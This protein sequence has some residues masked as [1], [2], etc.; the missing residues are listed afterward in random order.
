MWGELTNLKRIKDCWRYQV[1]RKYNW[2]LQAKKPPTNTRKL[3]LQN[4]SPGLTW[5]PITGSWHLKDCLEK[6]GG[7]L[8]HTMSLKPQSFILPRAV[9]SL[10]DTM[11]NKETISSAWD[12]LFP[13]FQTQSLNLT[14]LCDTHSS[15]GNRN[16][17]LATE[18]SHLHLELE[19]YQVH[20]FR[21]IAKVPT[22]AFTVTYAKQ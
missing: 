8:C 20:L 2:H 14:M 19:L 17:F 6:V 4:F 21:N 18:I 11:W 9:W 16:S 13:L 22:I 10:P 7:C 15:R 3:K 1:N 5:I 12:Q